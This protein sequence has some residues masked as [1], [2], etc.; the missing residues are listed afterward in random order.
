V[1][2]GTQGSYDGLGTTARFNNPTGVEVTQDGKV[3]Y[4]ADRGNS[5]VRRIALTD[6]DP[7]N[8]ASWTVSTIAGLSQTPGYINGAGDSARFNATYDVV[9]DSEGTLYVSE[10]NGNRIRRLNFTGGD[11][12]VAANWLVSLV[13]GDDLGSNGESGSADGVGNAARFSFP[14]G[15]GID[16]TGTLYVADRGN[17]RLRKVRFT[18]GSGLGNVSTLAGSTEGYLDATGIA[19]QFK[20]LEDVA[21]DAAGY[22]YAADYGYIRRISPTGVV[23]TVAGNGSTLSIDGSGNAASFVAPHGVA[24]D[25][26]GNIYVG[27]AWTLRLVQRVISQGV[28]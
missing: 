17:N 25:S 10:L 19:A 26:S 16:R 22:L 4:V 20:A 3:L 11:P 9:L 24:L 15:L 7:M 27:D 8:P 2:P 6:S 14:R 13:A 23:T 21:A 28:P 12:S 18:E 5:T 1:Q